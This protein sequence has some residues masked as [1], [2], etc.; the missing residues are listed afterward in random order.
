MDFQT[1]AAISFVA[2]LTIFVYLKRKRLETKQLIPY[3]L[4]FSMYKTKLGLKLMDSI[5]KRH[6]KIMSYIGYLGILVGFLGMALISYGLVNNIYLLFTKPE[7]QPGVGLVLPFKAKGVFFVPFFYWITAIFVIAVVHEF[8]HGVIARAHNLKVKSSGFAFLGLIVPVIPAAFVEPDEKELRKRPHREQLS[9]FAA[10]PFSNI[11]FAFFFLAVASFII[12]PV[13]NAAIEPNGVKITDYVNEKGP[14]PAEKAGIRIGES[15]QKVNDVPTPYVG[16]LSSVLKSKKPNDA[17]TIKTD[18]STY[19]LKLAKN[20][21]NESMAYLGAY[22]EQNTK[23]NESIKARFG[24]F[25]P[26]ALIWVYG[27]F[28]I[29]IV[30]NFGIGLF[31]LVPIGPLDGGRMLQLALH[32]FFDKEK[33]DKYWGYIGLFFLVLI[34]INI[35]AG[36]VR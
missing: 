34:F 28:V 19:E 12:A 21:E 27:L 23:I 25:L 26:N 8:A 31:N 22:L 14:F 24:E 3:F 16:N 29:L 15:I 17:V 6:S 2:A 5:G 10:G 32:K 33:G 30:L 20:P 35:A 18:K 4:Y 36:F 11:L 1:I 9:V 13:A 7:A